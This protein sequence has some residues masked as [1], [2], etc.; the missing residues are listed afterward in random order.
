[1]IFLDLGFIYIKIKFT[2]LLFEGKSQINVSKI[3]V[4]E[5]YIIFYL[6]LKHLIFLNNYIIT[7]LI[8]SNYNKVL[9]RALH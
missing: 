8:N 4:I 1:M 5:I 2:F 7:N 3:R 6:H 9:K